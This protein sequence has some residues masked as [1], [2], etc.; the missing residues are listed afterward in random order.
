[1]ALVAACTP[2]T[3]GNDNGIDN[4][5]GSLDDIHAAIVSPSTSFP[6]SALGS[7]V[8][9]LYTVS[10]A[11][12]DSIS[13]FYVPAEGEGDLVI[14]PTA[15]DLPP[16]TNRAFNFDPSTV[17][18]GRYRVGIRVVH[19]GV[20]EDFISIGVIEV[21]GPPAPVFRQPAGDV[22]ITQGTDVSIAFDAGDPEGD[23]EWRLFYLTPQD[24]RDEP[25]DELGTQLAVGAGNIGLFTFSTSGLEPGEYEIGIS[26]TDSGF[27]VATTVAQMDIDRIVTIPGNG[28]PGRKI[29]VI[30][31]PEPMPP[32]ISIL[33]PGVSDV[34]IFGNE[35]LALQFTGVV[36]EPGAVGQIDIFFDSDT[37]PENGFTLIASDLSV[38]ASSFRLPGDLPEGTYRIGACI[39]DG[40]NPEV[41]AYAVGRVIVV[42]V[43]TLVVTAPNT[44]LPIGRSTSCAAGAA[45]RITTPI[46]WTTNVPPA[47]GRTV[48]VFAQTVDAAGMAFGPE[49][50]VLAPTSVTTTSA[51][52]CS[53][54]SGLFA[55]SVRIRFADAVAPTLTAMAR[56]PIRVSSLPRVL[57]LGS[58]ADFAP[59]FEG[60]IFEGVNFE[61]NAGSAFTS[62]GDLDGDGLE[63]FVIAA[64]YGKPF[65][66][67]PTG[68]GPGEGYLL[69]GAGGNNKLRGSYQL[70][71][72]GTN[73]LRGVTLTGIRTPQ[74]S[75]A[76]DGMSIVSRVPDVDGDGAD[77]IMFGFPNTNSRGHN[78]HPEQ[79]GVVD[80]RSL[81]TLEREGQF[82][83][84]GVVILSSQN[85]ILVDPEDGSAVIN[86]DLV[87]QD[88][89]YNCVGPEPDNVATYNR[90][91]FYQNVMNPRS[92]PP[93]QGSCAMPMGGGAS[94]ANG[95]IDF[96][97]ASALARD[98]FYTYVYSHNE[99][100]G[101]TIC[102]DSITPFVPVECDPMLNPL[103]Y[104]RGG[105]P[106]GCPPYSPGLHAA[107]DSIS[108]EAGLQRVDRRSGF[109]SDTE[110]A[111]PGQPARPNMPSEPLGARIIGVG[112][113][114][115]FG[116]SVTLSNAM[117]IGAGDVI[118]SSPGR[119]G[120][121]I[122]LGARPSGCTDPPSCG[123]EIDGLESAVGSPKTN[124]DSG[125]AYLFSLRSLWTNDTFGR[126][127]PKPH[128][129]IV[130]EGSHCGG[131]SDLIDNI[132]AIRIV[133]F[134]GDKISNIVGIDDFN[135]DGRNDFAIGAPSA[136]NGQ[137]RV[138][139]G[140]RRDRAVEGDYVLEKLSLNPTS[141]DRLTGVLITTSTVDGLGASLVTGVDFNGDGLSD[142]VV[143]SPNASSGVGEVIV[144]FGDPNL[145][146]P[147]DGVS[148]QTLLNTRTAQGL[149][150]AARITGNALD[151]G[152]LF[153]FNVA[154]AG[155]VD[156]DGA[157]DLLI[158]APNASPR[159]D[160]NPND[161]M[162]TLAA[163][164]LDVDF[165]GQKD[166]V[167]G[168]FKV[169][170]GLVDTNDNLPNA[171]IVYLIS[172]RNRLDRIA[173]TNVTI[174]VSQLGGTQ[175]RG[176]MI[177][178]RRAGDRIG[179]GD[180]G[181]ASAGGIQ[182]K[183]GRGRSQGLAS[184]GDVDGDGEADILIG[185]ILADP[186]VDPNTG[187]GK[188][189]GGE[190]YLIYSSAAAQ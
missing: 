30:V 65:F 94:D 102:G 60:A 129:Y 178:G 38:G 151:V 86:L 157:S 154:N 165:D 93:C 47:A 155:D 115:R 99:F 50:S 46:T 12:P 75:N 139:I 77:E 4:G 104:C 171:G 11:D 150:R 107:V 180:A 158:A 1:M 164:G 187:V 175:L 181:N 61:D 95:S 119:T 69:Y 43:P 176:F 84:G 78:V 97:F 32:A 170:D 44:T 100:G 98:Y 88:F 23:V 128:Q 142:L 91:A 159:Y 130:G 144:I 15:I 54:T 57:W 35:T 179:G 189:N 76:T 45:G 21:Q 106:P 185:S 89:R 92:V 116:T 74:A 148:V 163:A 188:Q 83:R 10:G 125:V 110:P 141:P 101:T 72:T 20:T 62:V 173:A 134:S 114:D 28:V 80:P 143:G 120:R 59:R 71:S 122:L 109:Y 182:G 58:L 152:G 132:E 36:R 3:P 117:D 52:F 67:N 162:D 190:A 5:G 184:A 166:D 186:G 63:E 79:N 37:N 131:P 87:G 81:G 123:G 103:R 48:E 111:S 136:N 149:P 113:G 183:D 177:V 24:S 85:S 51:E 118:I 126:R 31:E 16:G 56:Q 168:P 9:V 19:A 53:V 153:G 167:S 17:G 8:S 169:P 6:L 66:V 29:N 121:G 34:P 82:L 13:G 127:P 138:Y 2:G 26:A 39:R 147:L 49:I 18:V 124:P 140:F 146:S 40:V 174:S 73:L 41:C 14:I 42:R 160:A 108:E 96:G 7:P 161:A 64:R 70:N 137:G 135:N 25:P 112:L 27:S 133:G 55:I 145:V 68:I 172:S 156:G 22:Q 33:V 90:Q 105:I